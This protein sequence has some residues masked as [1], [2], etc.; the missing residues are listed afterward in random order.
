MAN[1]TESPATTSSR[2]WFSRRPKQRIL[3]APLPAPI[4]ENIEAI[5]AIHRQ[6]AEKA[7]TTEQI[8]EVVAS[9]FSR[10]GFLYLLLLSLGLWLGGDALNH[11]GLLPFELPTFGWAD[12]GLDAASLLISTG[13]LIRQNR[14]ESFA[15][16]RTQLMLQLNLLS[17]KKIAKI[18]ALIEELREDLPDI[19]QRYDHEAA[20][21]QISTDPLAVL[22]ALKENLEEEVSVEKESRESVE[23][24]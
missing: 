7:S 19:V 3:T 15:E 8:L 10:P 5:I 4:A 18:I 20:L 17:E 14:Q 1:S 22:E 6:E 21:M 13:V 12:Q 9:W 23:D 24:V 16:Q 2:T 11:A